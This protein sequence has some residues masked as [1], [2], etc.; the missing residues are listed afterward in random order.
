MMMLGATLVLLLVAAQTPG[1]EP[2][3]D[4]AALVAQLGAARYADREAAAESLE[5]IGRRALEALRGARDSRDPEVRTRAWS[6]AQKIESALLAQPTRLR[7]DFQNTPLPDV[8][9]ALSVQTGFKIALYP[10]NLPRWREQRVDLRE[11]GLVDFWKAIDLFCDLAGLQYNANMHGHV[12]QSEPIFTLTDGASRV[13][14]PVSDHGP[15]RVSLLSLDYQRHLGYGPSGR[16]AVA[17]PVPRPAILEPAPDKAAA[18]PR[19]NPMTSVQF[20]AQLLLAAEPRL[21]FSHVR[22]LELAEAIDDG[23]NSLVPTGDDETIYSRSSGYIGV[24]T[25]PVIQ[26]HVPLRRPEVAGERIKKLRGFVP[27]TISARRPNPLVVP[28][29]SAVGK[30]FENQEHRLTVH[31]MRQSPN[32]HNPMLELS[33]RANDTDST[34]DRAEPDGFSDGLQ[35]ADPQHLQIEVVDTRGQLIPSFQSGAEAETGRFTLTLT[36]L[37]QTSQPKELHYYTLT[38]A[39]VK[40]PFEFTDIPMP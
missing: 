26:L 9:H 37:P 38:R 18:P 1:K 11:P 14:M 32:N 39:S 7:L 28:L 30:T 2:F 4:V 13:V 10:S 34:A 16:M 6:L 40:V 29:H 5:R 15:F 24:T 36:M 25:G 19:P 17:P 23:G 22:P 8:T 20:S 27:L 31:G 21:T 12:G 35:R 3:E 33:I